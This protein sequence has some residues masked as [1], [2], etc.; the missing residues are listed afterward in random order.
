[1]PFKGRFYT[2]QE[3]QKLL[4]GVTRQNI[5]QLA[6]RKK[7]GSPTPGVFYAEDVEGYLPL[8]IENFCPERLPWRSI[9][10]QGGATVDE[11]NK[12]FDILLE[13]E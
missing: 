11:E 7:W 2:T 12:V 3:L 13:R 10:F 5:R 6:Q 9:D 8:R 1:M 4:G